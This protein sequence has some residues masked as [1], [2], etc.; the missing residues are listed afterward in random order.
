MPHVTMRQSP[1][2]HLIIFQRVDRRRAEHLPKAL[3]RTELWKEDVALIADRGDCGLRTITRQD[4]PQL[5][6]PLRCSQQEYATSSLVNLAAVS[7]SVTVPYY[8]L[9]LR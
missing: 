8:E 2:A 7:P 4:Q 3:K 5:K 9:F 1:E 6:Q